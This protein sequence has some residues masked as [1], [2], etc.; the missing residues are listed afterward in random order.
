MQRRNIA[1]IRCRGGIGFRGRDANLVEAPKIGVVR[2]VP[3]E[4]YALSLKPLELT[5]ILPCNLV[6]LAPRTLYW[7][8]THARHPLESVEFPVAFSKRNWGG[9]RIWAVHDFGDMP[10]AVPG[11]C[12]VD[13]QVPGSLGLW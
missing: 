3:R 11:R 4:E 5:A 1:D 8:V 9:H 10:D 13:E 2:K 6:Q 12:P 7:R